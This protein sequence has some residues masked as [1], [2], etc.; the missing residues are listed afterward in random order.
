MFFLSFNILIFFQLEM[1]TLIL[2]NTGFYS[3]GWCLT[4]YGFEL[5]ISS[6]YLLVLELDIC[7][8]A[9]FMHTFLKLFLISTMQQKQL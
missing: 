5:M 6:L 2:F 7:H 9:Q 1:P 3:S 8:H 4:F